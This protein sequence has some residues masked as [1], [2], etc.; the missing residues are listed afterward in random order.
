MADKEIRKL[1]AVM[2]TDIE[3]YTA[4]VQK[5]ETAALRK[6]ATH[7]KHLE[8]FTAEYNGKV[9][10]FYGDGSL[11]I[12]DSALDAVQCGIAMQKAYREENPIP[13]RIGIHVGDIVLKDETVFGD[14]VN[15]ASR[16]QTSG[17]PGSVYIS[18]RVNSELSNHPEIKTKSIGKKKLKNV[19]HPIEVFVVTNDGLAIPSGMTR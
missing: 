1:A 13:V 7:R 14:G 6:V 10:A 18:E 12:Y 5:D 9:I 3:G 19:T 2:F 15:I 8:Q 16:L 17:I 4:F 11:S